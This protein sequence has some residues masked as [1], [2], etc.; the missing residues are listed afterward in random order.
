MANDAKVYKLVFDIYPSFAAETVSSNRPQVLLLHVA[1]VHQALRDRE[2]HHR[3]PAQHLQV[4][5]IDFYDLLRY[6][7]SALFH[8]NGGGVKV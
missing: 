2:V 1:V 4:S 5:T 3:L 6:L 8:P 7:W